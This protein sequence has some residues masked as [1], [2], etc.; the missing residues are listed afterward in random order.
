[1]KLNDMF[2]RRYA[3][4]ADLNGKAVTLTISSVQTER[5]RPSPGAPEQRKYVVY[6]QEAQKGVILSRTLANQID[7]ATNNSTG[8]TDNWIDQRITLYPQPMTVAGQPR[9][10]I[11]AR[12]PAPTNGHDQPPASLQDNDQDDDRAPEEILDENRKVLHGDQ[13]EI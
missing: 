4:G 8:D 12:K 11:R 1:M 13:V 5:M 3:N 9:I 10:A 6:F 2:P 7:A